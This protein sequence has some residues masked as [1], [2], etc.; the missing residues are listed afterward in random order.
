[1]CCRNLKRFG[2]AEDREGR[3]CLID[4]NFHRLDKRGNVITAESRQNQS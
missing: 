4:K 1:M 2:G 3:K